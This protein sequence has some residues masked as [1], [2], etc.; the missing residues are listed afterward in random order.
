MCLRGDRSDRESG[1][2]A[3]LDALVFFSIAML[4]SGVMISYVES[5]SRDTTSGVRG[6]SVD[7][8]E[9]LSVVMKASIG[10]E[11]EV[12]PGLEISGY[13]SVAECLSA[14]L[15]ALSA[16]IEPGVFDCLNEAIGEMI[17]TLSGPLFDWHILVVHPLGR[18]SEPCLAMPGPCVPCGLA[19]A[20]STELPCNDG[21]LYTV[22]LILEPATLPELVQV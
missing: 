11:V 21:V 1:Q 17:D 14:E 13:E 3:L 2:L 4:V 10:R 6:P 5:S 9:V 15:H 20:A 7:I 18:S 12:L 8:A 19:Y 22:I 16:N